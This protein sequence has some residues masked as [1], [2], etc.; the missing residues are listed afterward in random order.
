MQLKLHRYRTISPIPL[1]YSRSN[2]FQRRL[3]LRGIYVTVFLIQRT[4]YSI[5]TNCSLLKCKSN[6]IGLLLRY[7][8]RYFLLRSSC[9]LTEKLREVS[10]FYRSFYFSDL[11]TWRNDSGYSSLLTLIKSKQ[12]FRSAR[13]CDCIKTE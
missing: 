1:I 4:R 10:T 6:V 11:V 2:H 12:M 9:R 13:T 8:I 5:R 7:R 3:L